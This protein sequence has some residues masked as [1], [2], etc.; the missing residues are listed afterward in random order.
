M[1]RISLRLWLLSVV[2]FLLLSNLCFSQVTIATTLESGNPAQAGSILEIGVIVSD[3]LTSPPT[4]PGNFALRVKWNSTSLTWIGADAGEL[5]NLNLGDIEA[6]FTNRNIDIFSDG[7][8]GNINL[9]PRLMTMRF[10]VNSPSFSA[11]YSIIIEPDP[12]NPQTIL[13]TDLATPIPA[14]FDYSATTTFG[15]P[16]PLVGDVTIATAIDSGDPSKAGDIIELGVLISGNTTVP[17]TAPGNFAI[18][19]KWSSTSLTWIGADAGELG[20]LHIGPLEASALT[21]FLDITSDGDAANANLLPRLMTLRFQVNS[22]VFAAPYNIIIEPDPDTPLTVL[23]TDLVTSIPPVFDYSATTAIG[24]P[25]PF[26]GSLTIATS[27]T[28]GEPCLPGDIIEVQVAVTANTTVPSYAPGNFAVQIGFNEDSVSFVDAAP[29]ELGNLWLG[30]IQGAGSAK[31]LDITCDGNAANLN[32]TPVFMTLRFQVNSP[33]F[34]SPYSITIIPDPA[35]PNP[36]LAADLITILPASFDWT[37]TQDLCTILPDIHSLDVISAFGAP[38]PAVGSHLYTSG[39]LVNASMPVPV[40]DLGGGI[41]RQCVGYEGQGA[42][43]VTG[44]TTSVTFAIDQPST[45]TWQW[46]I[47]DHLNIWVDDDWAGSPYLWNLGAGRYFGINAFDNLQDAIAAVNPTGTIFIYDGNYVETGQIVIGNDMTII[48]ESKAGVVLRPAQDTLGAGDGSGWWLVSAGVTMNLSGVTLD[49]AGFN[50]RQGIRMLGTGVVEDC[51]IQNIVFPGSQGTGLALL[52]DDALVS[53]NTLT[54][55]G[56][57]GILGST[58]RNLVI[59][60]NVITG[61]GPAADASNGIEIELGSGGIIS[62]NIIT[63]CSGLLGDPLGSAAVLISTDAADPFHPGYDPDVTLTSNTI[64]ANMN[65]IAVGVGGAYTETSLVRA[66]FNSIVGNAAYGILVRQASAAQVDAVENWWGTIS[67]AGY[68]G[69]PGVRDAISGDV[70]CIPWC[71]EDFTIQYTIPPSTVADDDNTTR[72]EGDAGVNGGLFGWDEFDSVH[73]A[74]K[75]V[76]PGGTAMIMNGLYTE[77]VVIGNSVIVTGESE[78]GVVLQAQALAPVNGINSVTVNL[79]AGSSVTLEQMTIRNGDYGIHATGGQL[80]VE[81]CTFF[82]NG[83]D[84]TEYT[85]PTTQ[86]NAAAD[87]AAYATGGAAIHMENVSNTLIRNNTIYENDGG[88]MFTDSSHIFVLLNA[89]HDN[90]GSGLSLANGLGTGCEFVG[91]MDNIIERNK[92]HGIS[93]S[94]GD[95]VVVTN[96]IIRDNWNTGI[97]MS[98]PSR[99]SAG[100]NTIETN[101]LHD[102]SG[103]GIVQDALGGIGVRGLPLAAPSVNCFHLRENRINNNNSPSLPVSTGIYVNND[104]SALPKIIEYNFISGQDRAVWITGMADTT[105]VMGNS[106]NA[107]EFT[108]ANTDP[109]NHLYAPAN[110]HGSADPAVVR[111]LN[112]AAAD[113]SPWLLSGISADALAFGFFP[114][115]A[116]LGVDDDSVDATGAGYIAEAVS[117]VFPGGEIRVYA[118]TYNEG[119]DIQNSVTLIAPDG[120]AATIVDGAGTARISTGMADIPFMFIPSADGVALSVDGFSFTT[121]MSGIKASD[122]N[123][124]ANDSLSIN[125]C[126]FSAIDPAGVAVSVEFCSADIGGSTFSGPGAGIRIANASDCNIIGNTI[127]G[128]QNYGITIN[129]QTVSGVAGLTCENILIQSN[130]IEDLTSSFFTQAFG[131]FVGNSDGTGTPPF[132]RNVTVDDNSITTC[133]HTGIIFAGLNEPGNGYLNVT[134]NIVSNCGTFAGW[135]YDGIWASDALMTSSY[136]VNLEYNH[137]LDNTE[138]GLVISSGEIRAQNNLITRND[139]GVLVMGGIADLGNGPLGSSGLNHISQNTTFN[140]HNSFAAD[141]KAELNYW[142]SVVFADIE[143]SVEHKPDNPAEGFV[144]F[145]PFKGMFDPD[146]V[147]VDRTFNEVTAGWGYDH[148]D[149]I[150]DGIMAVADSGTVNVANGVYDAEESYP[151]NIQRTMTLAGQSTAAIIRNPASFVDTVTETGSV[152]LQI[153]ADNISISG[154]TLDGDNDPLVESTGSSELGHGLDGNP[155]ND[156]TA[157]AGIVLNPTGA[158]SPGGSLLVQNVAFQNF[159][160]GIRVSGIS[161]AATELST[162]NVIA[163][164]SFSNIGAAEKLFRK[165][166][167]VLI[168]SAEAEV[169]SS[170]FILCDAGVRAVLDP[171]SGAVTALAVH[172]NEFVDNYFGVFIDGSFN[173][174]ASAGLATFDPDGAGP[175]LEG[176]YANEFRTSDTFRLDASA[177][178]PAAGDFVEH[179]N[180][181]VATSDTFYGSTPPTMAPDTPVGLFIIGAT[182]PILV[183]DNSFTNL[184]RGIMV[185][186]ERGQSGDD[187]TIS[188][189][190]NFITGTDA[191]PA[192]DAVGIL[193]RNRQVYG[194][195]DAENDFGGL[196]KIN[197]FGNIINGAVDLV[198]LQ[199]EPVISLD[200]TLFEV[201]IGGAPA[202]ENI[203]GLIRGQAINLG[204]HDMP[205]GGCVSNVDATYNDFIVNRYQEAEDAI[206]H[207]SDQ[208]ELGLVTF[209]PARR[210]AY[211]IALDANPPAVNDYNITVSLTAA[212]RDGFNTFVVDGIPVVF[213]TDNGLLGTM[214]PVGT[215]GGIADN[216]LFWNRNGIANVQAVADDVAATQ[217]ISIVYNVT[218]QENLAFYPLDDPDLEGWIYG[219]PQPGTYIAAKDGAFYMAPSIR[220]PGIIGVSGNFTVNLFG[221]WHQ[222][223]GFEIPY[224]PN[225]LYRARYS[226]RTDQSDQL[227]VPQTRLRWTNKAFMT[228]A[229]QVIDRG[230]SA[231]RN[232]QWIDYHSYFLPP[233]LTGAP[234]DEKALVLNFDLVDFSD[235]QVGQLL[236]GEVE[237][238]RFNA[239]PRSIATSVISYDTESD[240]SSWVPVQVPTVYGLIPNGL[241][242]D[243]PWLESFAV[244]APPSGMAGL[245]DY[246]AWELPHTAATASYEPDRLY[247]AIFTLK[248]VNSTN[249]NTV[250]RVRCRLHNGGNDW[251]NV[252]EIYQLDPGFYYGHMPTVAGT[253][254]SVFMESP[255]VLYGAGEEFKNLITLA[256]DMVDGKATEYGRVTLDRVDVEYYDIP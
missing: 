158:T 142:G 228:G 235:V 81:W 236:L 176:V 253:E 248:V 1:T 38:D 16:D 184:R 37:G 205:G 50:I 250:S 117:T 119:V 202:F 222:R 11:P 61:L 91:L 84:G 194:D 173:A 223:E 179:C 15:E 210:I 240:F 164:C 83:Y 21:R 125:N 178:D 137:I 217:T 13:A 42:V 143:A 155:A 180:L 138:N 8:A 241:D 12:D 3:N 18:R 78:T 209:V 43:P 9:Y 244:P 201:V 97:W 123:S 171:A 151:L 32:P 186:S 121:A 243:G 24:V 110:W 182:N 73:D 220:Q 2:T 107:A 189:L 159:F 75:N 19:V 156:V 74:A 198:R 199:E 237:V 122:L 252:F 118:G 190:N 17:P 41:L 5:G 226:V 47:Q 63:D 27:I 187:G 169:T 157:L 62:D 112:M 231:P 230:L 14:I 174:N 60:G 105:L 56:K 246:S 88:I 213:T 249:Q 153:S 254:Y 256:F 247:R 89:I 181:D 76:I 212:V 149:N 71:N 113:Y 166:A 127:S 167:A 69:L 185:Q 48:G 98:G 218:G 99:I 242:S 46:I 93:S 193:G 232:D 77:S 215:V 251:S 65:G 10:Q 227:K 177:W 100:F 22:P 124:F 148:F 20:D 165:G 29:G 26:A 147:W 239:P 35:S 139:I 96:N 204:F 80:S 154:F 40:I 66:H 245:P 233:D 85:S 208:S 162:G 57:T 172:N 36:V 95:L 175:V 161:G 30:D 114:D 131:I 28:D 219:D 150:T 102:F 135:P 31:T 145:I 136:G 23:A 146:P 25:G 103:Y 255:R 86:V 225:K 224:A 49:G 67:W 214:A 216:T 197:A 68:R 55:F 134:N 195:S 87:Y 203:F 129:E 4:A 7:N 52:G 33:T 196:V 132:A 128:G 70:A 168:T 92:S 109:V 79:A 211:Q 58:A 108:V 207:R 229:S 191:D 221:Y 104:V 53:S 160:E 72:T 206:W 111:A 39:T 116:G 59:T 140:L 115:L 101:G 34:N 200:P 54:N 133:G 120:P 51:I 64:F 152:L 82:H 126:N 188:L 44:D 141:M 6:D 106:L 45:I 170:V 130:V 183:A 144:D 192:Y 90:L 234:E 163:E 94:G 238:E